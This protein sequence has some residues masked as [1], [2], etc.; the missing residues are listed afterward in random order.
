MEQSQ[1]A[2]SGRD[3]DLIEERAATYL[4]QQDENAGKAAFAALQEF[5]QKGGS[6]EEFRQQW[7]QTME[8]ADMFAQSAMTQQGVQ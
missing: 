5:V 1:I 8:L 2:L 4:E 7:P 6:T 3:P